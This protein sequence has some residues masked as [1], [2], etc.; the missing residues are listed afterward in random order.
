[1]YTVARFLANPP[2]LS[3]I[4]EIGD[5]M[6]A[7]KPGT[8]TGLRRRGDGFVCDIWK[9]GTWSEHERAIREFVAE[10]AGPIRQA[11]D[12]GISVAIDI[13]IGEED[14]ESVAYVC[15]SVAPS[16]LEALGS[17]GVRLEVTSY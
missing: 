5:A 10:F 3:R 4:S 13:A 11:R 15:I 1:M 6:N 8:F 17:A 14:R 7:V 16:L 9:D 2:A 12:A